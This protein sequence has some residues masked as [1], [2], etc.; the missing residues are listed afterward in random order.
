MTTRMLGVEGS[1]CRHCQAAVAEA[2][3]SVPGVETAEVSLEEGRSTVTY[4]PAQ[5]PFEKLRERSTRPATGWWSPA[6]VI[7]PP[8]PQAPPRTATLGVK[9]TYWAPIDAAHSR[10]DFE[11]DRSGSSRRR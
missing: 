8:F 7:R 2:L 9:R 5:A 11:E 6:C 10:S 1:S 3:R 4:D